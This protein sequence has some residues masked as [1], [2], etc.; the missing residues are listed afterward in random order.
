MVRAKLALKAG[1]N[2]QSIAFAQQALE[3]ARK[4]SSSDPTTD[5]YTIGAVYRLIGDIRQRMGNGEAAKAAWAAG[6]AQLPRNAPERPAEMDERAQLLGR[7]GRTAEA[8]PLTE[9]LKKM[10]YG[11]TV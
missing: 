6:L 9:S 1:E 7:L 11:R 2:Q 4:E 8:R 3:A 10:G 5:R